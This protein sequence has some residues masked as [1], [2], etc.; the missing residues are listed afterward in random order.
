MPGQSDCDQRRHGVT[1]DW[2][3]D[4]AK[5][6]VRKSRQLKRQLRDVLPGLSGFTQPPANRAERQN[7]H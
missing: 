6:L 5:H 1:D 4:P 2:K 7:R 3:L